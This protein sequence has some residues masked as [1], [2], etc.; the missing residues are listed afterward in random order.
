MV[1]NL[2]EP[3]FS[4]DRN[5][6]SDE[7]IIRMMFDFSKSDFSNEIIIALMR[8]AA[9]GIFWQIVEYLHT[10]RSIKKTDIEMV[11]EKL[12]IQKT[13][14]EKILTEYGLFKETEG[15]YISE[16]VLKNL[17][18]N[19]KQVEKNGNKTKVKENT[20]KSIIELYNKIFQKE[21]IVS[22]VNKEKIQEIN[23]KNELTLEIWE[24]V[25]SNAKK[26]WDIDGK[27]NVVPSL[28]KILEEWDSFAS[29][30]YFLAPDR[31]SAKK[32]I[33]KDKE[34]KEQE[35]KEQAKRKEEFEKSKNS[36][37]DKESAIAHL[38]KY[39]NNSEEFL[40]KSSIV[41]EYMNKYNF[42][43]KDILEGR[44]RDKPK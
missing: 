8:H 15:E 23:D 41:K 28:K 35:K 5:T 12:R 16:R 39:F 40:K 3:Y 33:E 19:N 14:L 27:K 44:E 42:T 13:I 38:N 7:K 11:A 1:K 32:D 37:K 36:V 10:N 34:S 22:D 18:I 9:Y 30:D 20:V 31:E 17:N 43:I 21:Q 6:T 24:K 26:G 29:D 4:H 2:V 25:F